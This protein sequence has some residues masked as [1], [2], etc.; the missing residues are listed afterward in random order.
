MIE[1][2]VPTAVVPHRPSWLRVLSGK[3]EIS[4]ELPNITN[5]V[6]VA[7]SI[8]NISFMILK[9]KNWEKTLDKQKGSMKYEYV[10][11]FYCPNHFECGYP[12]C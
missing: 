4:A 11:N 6:V 5:V 10:S 3:T 2:D 12:N 1:L 7:L 8:V 9:L